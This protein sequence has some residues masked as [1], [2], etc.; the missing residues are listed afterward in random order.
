MRKGFKNDVTIIRGCGYVGLP[1]ALAFTSKGLKVTIYD[2]NEAVVEQV[3]SGIM[4]FLELG[5][6][7]ILKNEYGYFPSYRNFYTDELILLVSERY[8]RDIELFNYKYDV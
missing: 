4:P 1:L 2:I 7:E 5:A 6:D 8:K 3:N